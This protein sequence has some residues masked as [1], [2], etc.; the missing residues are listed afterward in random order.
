MVCGGLA[1]S[2]CVGVHALVCVGLGV[3]VFMVFVQMRLL[4]WRRVSGRST[5]LRNAGAP[6]WIY[7]DS[8]CAGAR[9]GAGVLAYYRTQLQVA[10]KQSEVRSA[11]VAAIGGPFSV[12]R[13]DG[14]PITDAD[15]RGRYLLLYFGFTNCPGASCNR[16]E[17]N[18]VAFSA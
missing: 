17:R 18:T 8:G 1:E 13:D 15:L 5:S 9:A 6:F 2:V 10:A 16:I 3:W 12:V 14:R 7:I 4:C 11:G